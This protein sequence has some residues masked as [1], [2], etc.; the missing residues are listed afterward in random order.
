MGYFEE[1][2]SASERPAIRI[3]D[4]I[5]IS[6]HKNNE[7]VITDVDS[8]TNENI[9]ID[10][11]YSR[12]FSK[13]GDC[14]IDIASAFYLRNHFTDFEYKYNNNESFLSNFQKKYHC[15]I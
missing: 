14:R 12:N 3:F 6:S 11:Q 10:V 8:L 7:R 2:T 5:G 9:K 13:Y 1:S 15:N 4:G